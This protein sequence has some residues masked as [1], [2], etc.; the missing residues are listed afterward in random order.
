[1]SRRTQWLAWLLPLAAIGW[2]VYL[3][4]QEG[5]LSWPPSLDLTG[6]VRL[7]Y[8]IDPEAAIRQGIES[9][10]HREEALARSQE[11]F[12]FRLRNFDLSEITVKPVGDDR[13]IVEVPGTKAIEG[14]KQEIGKAAVLTFRLVGD[15]VVQDREQWRALPEEVRQRHFRLSGRRIYLEVGEPLLDASDISYKGTRVEISRPTVEAP[16]RGHYIRLDLMLAAKDRFAQITDQHFG[17]QLAICL[18]DQIVSAPKIAA[19]GIREP[20]IK[21]SFTRTEGEEMASILRAGPLPISFNLVSETLVSPGLGKDALKRGVRSIAIGALLVLVL[22]SLAYSD[23]LAMLA[24]IIFCLSLEA[25]LIFLLGQAGWL[26]L[27][28]ISLSGLIVLIGISVDNLI[29]IFEE[30]RSIVTE[31]RAF[32]QLAVV[33]VLERA[34][35]G[36]MGIILLANL[37]TVATLLPLLL[38]KGSIT[39]LVEMMFL[40]IIVALLVNVWFARRLLREE[41]LVLALE[42]AAVSHLP[43][44]SFRFNLFS[45]RRPLLALYLVAATSSTAVIATRGFELGLDFQGGTELEI[46]SDQG[47]GV[48]RLRTYAAEYFG[49]RCE[50]KSTADRWSDGSNTYQYIVR[51]PRTEVLESKPNPGNDGISAATGVTAE[52]FVEH[53]RQREPMAIRLVSAD[54]LGA[55]VVALNRKVVIITVLTSLVLLAIVIRFNYGSG[56]ALPVVSALALDGLIVL[57]AVSLFNIPLSLPVVAA[58]LTVL[59]YSINDSIVLCG[60]IHRGENE[61]KTWM[62]Q[63]RDEELRTLQKAPGPGAIRYFDSIIH[64]LSPRVLLTSLTTTGVAATLWVLGTGLLRDFGLVITVGVLFGTISSISLVAMRLQ[65]LW[66]SSVRELAAATLAARELNLPHEAP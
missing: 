13:L 41:R 47:I 5:G 8:R 36:E 9:P 49:E 34:F 20:I 63:Q 59:G 16:E 45:A 24:T 28:M 52:G 11:I 35:E 40:G 2:T 23:H 12:L 6:G 64:P 55:T 32:G 62:E 44:L 31:E 53:L 25:L 65:S 19:R 33:Q 22:M 18:D 29:L 17:R 51:V 21:G 57:G 43:V 37:T 15:S 54:L 39:N 46:S 66:I 10:A 60:H 48:E 1:M 61:L 14:V 26:T 3:A 7:E 42:R 38:L 56:Y 50:V 58:I 30:F 4:R 27:N